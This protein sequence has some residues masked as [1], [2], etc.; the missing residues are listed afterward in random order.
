MT[1]QG[2]EG[3]GGGALRGPWCRHVGLGQKFQSHCAPGAVHPHSRA[4]ITM[5]SIWEH[6]SNLSTSRDADLNSANKCETPKETD[7]KAS[8]VPKSGGV[9]IG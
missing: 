4:V 8:N 2:Q 9:D 1:L 5:T 7:G 6:S 3:G